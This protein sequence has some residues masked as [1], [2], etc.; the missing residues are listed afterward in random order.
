MPWLLS[1][2]E[3]S[4]VIEERE[5]LTLPPPPQALH[6]G[7]SGLDFLVFF[8]NTQIHQ[9]GTGRRRPRP[10]AVV[11][12]Q[13]LQQ[14]DHVVVPKAPFQGG[15][16]EPDQIHA[17]S[18]LNLF[19]AAHSLVWGPYDSTSLVPESAAGIPPSRSSGRGLSSGQKR[20]GRV[21][22]VL[23]VGGRSGATACGGSAVSGR[24]LGA[25]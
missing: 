2:S 9:N 3:P 22:G 12:Q 1:T 4:A 11:A 8:G 17:A 20:D 10:A 7:S 15:S 21:C 19:G 16:E 25:F 13:L 6:P 14:P 18:G 23:L 24:G 5:Q